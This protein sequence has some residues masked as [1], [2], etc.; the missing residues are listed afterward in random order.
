MVRKPSGTIQR[1]RKGKMSSG[2]IFGWHN[3]FGTKKRVESVEL[4]ILQINYQLSSVISFVYNSE[5]I[6]SSSS[7]SSFSPEASRFLT[8][9]VMVPIM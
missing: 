7:F 2:D 9:S 1:G 3:V 4:F 5:K 6:S 8:L